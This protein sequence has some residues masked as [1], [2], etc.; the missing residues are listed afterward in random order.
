MHFHFRFSVILSSPHQA[1]P[2][3]SLL[4]GQQ[5]EACR[6]SKNKQRALDTISRSEH[7]HRRTAWNTVST[8]TVVGSPQRPLH[9][10]S[11]STPTATASIHIYYHYHRS[12]PLPRWPHLPGAVESNTNINIERRPPQQLCDNR[13][14]SP[15]FTLPLFTSTHHYPTITHHT[16]LLS[17]SQQILILPSALLSLLSLHPSINIHPQR[18]DESF[19]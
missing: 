7:I 2:S 8:I 18:H 1:T 13:Y 17:R 3:H 9:E 14:G 11:Q 12:S 5:Q 15:P 16:P 10:T 4:A 6:S 19:G